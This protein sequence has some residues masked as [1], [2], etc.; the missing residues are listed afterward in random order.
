VTRLFTARMKLGLFDPPAMV[1]YTHINEDALN[2]AGHKALALRLANESMVLLKN[3]GTLPL[4]TQGIKIALIGPLASQTK[5]LLGNYNGIPL[6]TVSILEGMHNEFA[7]DTIQYVEGTQFLSKSAEPVP[8]GALK[9]DGKPGVKATY[10]ER[11]PM[12]P[13]AA[14]RKAEGSGLAQ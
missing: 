3:D 7:N 11:P 10:T 2:S 1:P 13:S 14:D 9:T 12:D 4:K 8:A 6:H 5:F